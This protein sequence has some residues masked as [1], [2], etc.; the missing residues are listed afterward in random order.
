MKIS[1]FC[2]IV[3]L[4]LAGISGSAAPA[5][6]LLPPFRVEADG[7]PILV[8]GAASPCMADFDGDGVLDLLVG[9]RGGCK[10]LVF[11]NVGS[12]KEPRF[13]AST[14]FRAGGVDA[15]LPRVRGH[16]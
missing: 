5:V 3:L 14:L 15:R 13:G 6:D 4:G 8:Q 2:S 11:R 1:L 9:Q 7:K 10:M 12:N 16:V